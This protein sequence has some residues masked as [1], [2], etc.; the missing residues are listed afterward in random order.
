[1]VCPYGYVGYGDLPAVKVSCFWTNHVESRVGVITPHFERKMRLPSRVFQR[2]EG[3]R[4]D[5]SVPGE[6]NKTTPSGDRTT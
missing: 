2:L 4:Y 3:R 6:V 5:D 1:M